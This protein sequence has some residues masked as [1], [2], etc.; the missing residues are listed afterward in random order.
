[1]VFT[2]L[3]MSQVSAQVSEKKPDGSLGRTVTIMK[4]TFIGRENCDLSYPHDQ[5][6]SQRH[7]SISL[8]DDKLML[9]D[10]GSQNGSFI[11][12]RQD[13]EL[14]P[15]DIFLLGRELFRFTT[16]SLD[17]AI[18]KGPAQGTVMW[19]G[20]PKLQKGPISAKLEHIKLNGEVVAEFKL[21]KPETTLGRSTGDLIFKD[22]PYM[23]G[24]HARIV[25]QP[26]RFVLQDLRSRN[27]VYRR[28]RNEIELEDGAEFFMGEQL[29]RVEVKN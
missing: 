29:F 20:P 7:A 4:E 16:Q 1:V 24:T 15:G 21:E 10:L 22:D 25:T 23:S 5:L 13:T 2:G 27:G 8:R 17:E 14:S 12:Q 19:S 9:K 3:H 18:N 28:V 6:L 11:R 26:G